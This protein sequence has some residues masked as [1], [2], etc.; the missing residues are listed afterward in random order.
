MVACRKT[1][2]TIPVANAEHV[3]SVTPSVASSVTPM[4]QRLVLQASSRFTSEEDDVIP[5]ELSK[6]VQE[7]LY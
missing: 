4:D 1:T 5:A 3:E 7:R 6:V 2:S